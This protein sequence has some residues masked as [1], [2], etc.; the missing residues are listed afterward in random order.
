MITREASIYEMLYYNLRVTNKFIKYYYEYFVK[1]YS[2]V[3]Q[4]LCLFYIF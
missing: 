4:V 3:F 2:S 1:M